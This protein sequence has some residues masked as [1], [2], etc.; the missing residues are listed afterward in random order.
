MLAYELMSARGTRQIQYFYISNVLLT[1]PS[2]KSL[3]FKIQPLCE[4]TDAGLTSFLSP[5]TVPLAVLY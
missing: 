3:I 4:D 1:D 5:V 2:R